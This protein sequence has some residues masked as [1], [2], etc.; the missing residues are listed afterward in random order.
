MQFSCMLFLRFTDWLVLGS[1]GSTR[2]SGEAPAVPLNQRR[3]GAA[4]QAGNHVQQ[5]QAG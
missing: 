5:F 2:G 3:R 1:E 4:V